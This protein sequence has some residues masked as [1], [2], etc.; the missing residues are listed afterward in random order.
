[1]DLTQLKLENFKCFKETEIDFGKITLLT[2][3]NSSGKSSLIYALLTMFQTDNFPFYFSPNGNLI[4]LGNF[5]NLVNEYDISKQIK[6]EFV[7]KFKGIEEFKL[8][9]KWDNNPINGLP[10]LNSFECTEFFENGEYPL[11]VFKRGENYVL[12]LF[13]EKEFENLDEII[14]G[15]NKGFGDG[16]GYGGIGFYKINYSEYF[17]FIHSYRTNPQR[18][19]LQTPKASKILPNGAGFENQIIEWEET[20]SPLFNELIA[21]LSKLGL[22]SGLSTNK[23]G[24]GMF[25][26][27]IQTKPNGILSS[28]IDVGFGVSKLLPIIVADLQLPNDS[29]LVISEPEIDLHPSIQANFANFLYEQTKKGKKYIIET[30]SEYIINR[31][32]LLIAKGELKE[33]DVKTYFFSNDG[34]KTKTYPINLKID[35]QIENAPIDFFD[36][37]EIDVME[38]AMQG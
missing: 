23:I 27:K 1:M 8:S 7:V 30:H 36:A 24:D 12:D 5:R 26:I 25:D 10:T 29:L 6:I 22:L 34:R 38:I 21:I 11:N 2:G 19:Y 37:Y 18:N 15:L 17:N 13:N 35:G 3:A 14:K 28:I 32:R 9:T 33:E 16:T 20:K 4:S 31:L